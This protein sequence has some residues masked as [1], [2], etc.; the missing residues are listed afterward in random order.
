MRY[1]KFITL[2]TF[3]WFLLASSAAAADFDWGPWDQI[4]KARVKVTSQA[5]VSLN[6]F[7]Y[8]TLLKSRASFDK[9]VA[10]L[11]KYDPSKLKGKQKL[12]F[13]INAYNLGAVKMVLDHPKIKS[14]N[15]VGPVRGAVWKLDALLVN[16]KTYS[17]DAIENGILRKLGEPRIHFA[18]VCASVSCPDIRPQA[19]QAKLL[20]NQLDD[21]TRSF[22]SN[23]KK[24][25]SYDSAGRKLR[26][27][28]L[29]K[30]FAADFG[31]EDH[32]LD[33]VAGYLPKDAPADWR[34]FAVGYLEYN[35]D[36][37]GL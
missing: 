32:I 26:L 4:L 19:Y 31:G 36:L 11:A 33:F 21:Q 23:T 34:K 25:L 13:W 1:T 22:L 24:G 16:S 17:L 10:D 37:N 9:L 7:D 35:W 3:A 8:R 27:T 2:L 30:W 29:L 28:H 18:I 14:L 5:G 12:A 15:E 6:G 20:D